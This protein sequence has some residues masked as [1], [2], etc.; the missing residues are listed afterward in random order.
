[1]VDPDWATGGQKDKCLYRKVR[2]DNQKVVWRKYDLMKP[3]SMKP[4]DLHGAHRAWSHTID[5]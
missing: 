5:L 1:M 4:D 2:G 3:D